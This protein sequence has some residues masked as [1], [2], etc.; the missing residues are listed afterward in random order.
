METAPPALLAGWLRRSEREFTHNCFIVVAPDISRSVQ[1]VKTESGR[2]GTYSKQN[3]F[4]LCFVE[5]V[6]V[7]TTPF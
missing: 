7:L 1:V 2:P 5:L 6:E 4:Q 3:A